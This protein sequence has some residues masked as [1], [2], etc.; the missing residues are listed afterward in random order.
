M[1]K[2]KKKDTRPEIQ[3]VGVAW[4]RKTKKGQEAIK[5]SI[6]KEIF[7]AHKNLKKSKDLDP[8]FVII[9]YVDLKEENK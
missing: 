5:I 8:D 1:D 3:K 2:A 4:L 7:V 6:N 9:K